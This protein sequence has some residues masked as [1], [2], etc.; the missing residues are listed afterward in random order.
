MREDAEVVGGRDADPRVAMIDAERRVRRVCV[1]SVH[2]AKFAVAPMR[3]QG[4]MM[5]LIP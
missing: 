1:S 4:C 2:K 3:W 5:M